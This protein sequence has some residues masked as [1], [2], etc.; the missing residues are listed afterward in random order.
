M[1]GPQSLSR[2]RRGA[3][4][5]LPWNLIAPDEVRY[6]VEVRMQITIKSSA[7]RIGMAALE[8][9]AFLLLT[10]WV[11]KAYFAN[12]VSHRV[13]ADDL[14]LATRLDPN[15]SEYHLELG[16]IYQYSLTDIDTSQAIAE[17]RLAA[18]K[19][20]FDAQPWLD[21]GAAQEIAGRVDDAEASL[22]RADYLAPRLPGFQWAIA[23]FF[24]LHGDVNEA[25]RH[26][27]IVLA[28]T[29]QYD[30]M[31][32][33]TAWKAVGNGDE[34]L[35]KLIP[36]NARPEVSYMYYLAGQNKPAEAQKV[37]QRLVAGHE[38]F[39]ARIVGPYID[40]LLNFH[41]PDDA[42]NDWIDLQKRGLVA[43][44]SEP[45][46][47][48]Y[49]GDFE[50]DI[51]NFGFGWRFF[52]PPGLYIGLDSTTFH[53][54]G[55]SV[56]IRFPGKENYLFRNVCE[57][58]KVSPRETY[59][60]RGF[61]RTEGITTNSGPRLEAYDPYDLKRLDAFSDQLLGTNAAWTLLSITF[62]T[63]PETRLVN[64]CV[65]RFPSDKLD[66]LIKGKV[67]VD[68]VSVVKAEADPMG[69]R[70]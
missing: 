12:V 16:R 68:D 4:A 2:I 43:P 36:D 22:R 14:R 42:Y 21:L 27:R 47:L 58:V 53:S 54:G 62:T 18:E 30:G 9:V 32:F 1:P 8:G 7:A 39:S 44:P 28:G 13:T 55:R 66:N 37:W 56:L 10:F 64:L 29:N 3:G 63:K 5:V 19:S 67:W 33:S 69:D 48:N 46:N 61:M 49:D 11:G 40:S 57:D 60:A 38:G 51:T 45:G 34:I 65:T 15:D 41:M 59:R 35:A 23:N 52:P 6:I 70:P 31:I 26:F 24:L 50:N 20:P 17:L 25:L